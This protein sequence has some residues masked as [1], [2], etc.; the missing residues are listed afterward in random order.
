[1]RTNQKLDSLSMSRRVVRECVRSF[2]KREAKKSQ[3]GTITESP[4]LITFNSTLF[5]ANWTDYRPERRQNERVRGRERARARSKR[6]SRKKKWSSWENT[7]FSPQ[8]DYDVNFHF[9]WPQWNHLSFSVSFSKHKMVGRASASYAHKK[10][11]SI[12]FCRTIVLRCVFSL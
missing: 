10:S 5:D 1:M 11:D 8:F 6:P 12:F 9:Q 3:L 2:M 4:Q 7:L